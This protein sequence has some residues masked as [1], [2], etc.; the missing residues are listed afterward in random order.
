MAEDYKEN[1]K[2]LRSMRLSAAQAGYMELVGAVKD[3]DCK[4][5]AVK[6]GVS[7]ELGCCNEFQ[8]EAKTTKQFRCGVCEYV[9]K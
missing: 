4:K 7:K 8:P 2:L 3:A 5:V 9:R 1:R 6:G